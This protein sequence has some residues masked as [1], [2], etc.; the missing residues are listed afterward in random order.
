[1]NFD[2]AREPWIRVRRA[3][4]GEVAEVGL[5]EAL[6]GAHLLREVSDPLPTVEFG[7]SRLLVAFALDIFF[8]EPGAARNT[9]ALNGLLRAGRFDAACVNDYLDRH[10]DRFD[11]FGPRPFLQTADM[12]GADKPLAGLLHPLPSGTNAAHFHHGHEDDFGVCPAAAARLL[13][14]I[15]PFMT[16]GG[17]G[18]SPSINGAPP[19]YVLV[20]GRTLFETLCRNLFALP[21]AQET[22]GEPPA[23]RSSRRVGGGRCTQASY[24]QSLTWQPRRIR[25]V[26]GPGGWCGLT[27]AEAPVLVR[28]MRFGPGDACDFL[29]AD[30]NCAYRIDDREADPTKALKVVRPRPGRAVWRDTGPLALL[31]RG[32][33]NSH[34]QRPRVLDQARYLDGEFFGLTVYGMRT[35]MKMKIFEWQRERLRLPTR[36]VLHDDFHFDAQNALERAEAAARLL[37]DAVKLAYPR[38]GKG[39]DKALQ[40]VIGYAER[41]FWRALEGPYQAFL[42]RLGGL[43]PDDLDGLRDARAGWKGDVTEHAR[44]IAY[45]AIDSFDADRAALER[46]TRALRRLEG[47]L[48]TLFETEKERQARL[49]GKKERDRAAKAAA[50]SGRAADPRGGSSL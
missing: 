14:T 43:A 8:G 12:E 15:A 37:R 7:L 23:W 33:R 46:Q 32:D 4:S 44:R 31:G 47:G 17:A 25:L 49:Q 18:L 38:E 10:A 11:L 22:P 28:A 50:K 41:E 6:T 36:L 39:N 20:T 30:P 45:E 3:G 5:R 9:E 42:E 29:W 26:P 13:A 35:D 16:A 21:L 27:G 34:F 19:F 24:A 2:L 40:T 1:M 48:R